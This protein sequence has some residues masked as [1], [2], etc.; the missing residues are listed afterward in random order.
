MTLREC[1]HRRRTSPRTVLKTRLHGSI[2]PLERASE[3]TLDAPRGAAPTSGNIRQPHPRLTI[4]PGHNPHHHN[5]HLRLVKHSNKTTRPGHNPHHHNTPPNPSH[6]HKSCCGGAGCAGGRGWGVCCGGA[7]CV[8]GGS[9]C[10]GGAGCAGGRG[11]GVCCGGAGCVQGAS[12]C[13][14]GA[15]CV[16]GASSCCGGAGCV[17]GASPHH[18]NKTTH[19]GHNPHHHN[20][21]THPGHNPHHHNKTTH[22]GNNPQCASRRC[23]HANRPPQ[24]TPSRNL[25]LVPP[26]PALAA[27]GG[28]C[29]NARP[30]KL[31]HLW[32]RYLKPS[33]RQPTCPKRRCG[34]GY[35]VCSRPSR[36]ATGQKTSARQTSR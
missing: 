5:T 7:G 35:E 22:L 6:P 11:W 15:G 10:C 28:C 29:S 23:G 17:Q 2:L 1:L 19:P 31:P 25:R 4:R 16:Q 13:C 21:T 18:H 34:N 12:S 30:K 32:G 9:S 3:P 26:S 33:Q 14:G 27:R 8:Q 24:G 36:P 20:K